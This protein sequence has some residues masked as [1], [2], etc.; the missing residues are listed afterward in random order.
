MQTNVDQIADRIYRI[1]TCIPDIA[2][3]A[4]TL[5]IEVEDRGTRPPR[6]ARRSLDF[7]VTNLPARVPAGFVYVPAGRFLYGSDDSED[8]RR[9]FFNAVPMHARESPAHETLD[10]A[11]VRAADIGMLMCGVCSSMGFNLAGFDW[12]RH[13]ELVVDMLRPR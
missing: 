2:P 6:K 5:W 10:R 8:L 13:F 12:E 3:G 9:G 1:S 11:D 7:R 4:Y